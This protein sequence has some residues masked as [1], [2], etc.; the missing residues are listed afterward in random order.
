MDIVA[1]TN[2]HEVEEVSK[3]ANA[4]G[5]YALA[6]THYWRDTVGDVAGFFSCG[7]I[8]VGHFWMRST[9]RPRESMLMIKKCEKVAASVFGS[10]I[11]Y[12]MIAC[13]KSSPFHDKLEKHFGYHPVVTDATLFG[14]KL[15]K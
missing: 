13:Q 8:P 6:P 15:S 1:V 9:A 10:S 3:A 11:R 2:L 5:H 4:D 7:V 14:I 12:G